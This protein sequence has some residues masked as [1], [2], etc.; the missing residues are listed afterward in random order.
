[1]VTY[2]VLNGLLYT[3]GWFFCVLCGAY[4]DT[5]PPIPFT[6][7]IVVG[8]LLFLRWRCKPI[9][10]NDLAILLY[11]VVLG[12]FMEVTFLSMQLIQYTTTNIVIA[13]FP[14]AWVWCLYFLFSLTYNHS[15]NFLSRKWFYPFLF[16]FVGGPVSYYAGSRLGAVTFTST[17]SIF[18]LAAFWGCYISLMVWINMKLNE[19]VGHL[20]DDK[21]LQKPIT[22]YFDAGCPICSKELKHLKSRKQTGKVVYFEVTSQEQFEK[23]VVGLGFI[24]VMKVIHGKDADGHVYQGVDVFSEL[25][26]RTNLQFVAV[27]LKAPFIAPLAKF[28]Y[29]IWAKRR[30]K[31]RCNSISCS[32]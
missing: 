18:I 25:Y 14:P 6:F 16:G 32:S 9:Y 20:L 19:L 21:H 23:E 28:L 30:F 2:R 17:E 29:K 12:F 5:F 3:F 22:V 4:G 1:M 15:L 26:A 27:L 7:T 10:I 13:L 31:S 24:D 11:G 8:Q